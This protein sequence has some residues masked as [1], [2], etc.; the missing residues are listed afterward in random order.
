MKLK[1][2]NNSNNYIAKCNQ[3]KVNSPHQPAL[4]LYWLVLGLLNQTLLRK[5]RQEHPVV[6]IKHKK[7]IRKQNF[8]ILL[9]SKLL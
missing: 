7:K 6:A 3:K 1:I 9:T 2:V 4:P 8:V 5:L